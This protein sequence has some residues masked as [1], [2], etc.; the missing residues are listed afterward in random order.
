MSWYI[1]LFTCMCL[2]V[3]V[4]CTV[5]VIRCIAE[6]PGIPGNLPSQKYPAGLPGN[7]WILEE[8]FREFQKCPILV[9]FCSDIVKARNHEHSLSFLFKFKSPISNY[10]IECRPF[11]WLFFLT[12]LNF[13]WCLLFHA[14][15]Y[16]WFPIW[17]CLFGN[18]ID[19]IWSESKAIIVCM[20]DALISNWLINDDF[21]NFMPTQGMYRGYFHNGNLYTVAISI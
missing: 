17:L 12:T 8:N 4:C 10:T 20:D 15:I 16:T 2:S 18:S 21:N 3:Y 5:I 19:R 9:N 11:Q 1:Y 7:Y 6:P 14:A 13:W